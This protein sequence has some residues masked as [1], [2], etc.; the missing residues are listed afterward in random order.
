RAVVQNG[1]DALRD[2][3]ADLQAQAGRRQGIEGW[4]APL[5]AVVLDQQYAVAALA[6]QDEAALDQAREDH[7]GA[8]ALDVRRQL[9]HV[10]VA[11]QA[12][13]YGGRA[14][15]HVA[16]LAQV[17]GAGRRAGGGQRAQQQPGEAQPQGRTA[18]EA[19]AH[20]VFLPSV[21]LRNGNRTAP[22]PRPTVWT[23][24]VA[25]K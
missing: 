12:L 10:G 3:P 25:K 14:V 23:G 9:A 4:R 24:I 5:T 6:T 15:E 19:K 13:E 7:H 11:L 17:V 20:G 8:G 22:L 16:S 21:V 2:L 1:Y 18:S